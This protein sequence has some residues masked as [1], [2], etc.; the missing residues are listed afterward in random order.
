MIH[1]TPEFPPLYP[2]LGWWRIYFENIVGGASQEAAIAIANSGCGLKNREWMRFRL[3]EDTVISLSIEGGASSLKNRP[4]GS[5]TMAPKAMLDARKGDAAIATLYGATPYF[6]L[7]DRQMSLSGLLA[8]SVPPG[9]GL[10][11]LKASAVC[12]EAFRRV[13]NTLGLSEPG[14]AESVKEFY[15][16]G[17]E[18]R[19]TPCG[20]EMTVSI[21]DIIFKKGR[22]TI[23]SLIHPF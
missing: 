11:P 22:E 14:L 17:D 13:E 19:E 9:E 20:N 15:R 7:L 23:F 6:S 21:L 8:G 3:R 16:T 2:P 1:P 18:V 4:S 12:R 5:W 10:M